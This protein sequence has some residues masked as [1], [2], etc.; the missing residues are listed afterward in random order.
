MTENKLKGYIYNEVTDGVTK[1]Y[2]E[3]RLKFT[4]DMI[5]SA[6][7]NTFLCGIQSNCKQQMYIQHFHS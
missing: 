6:S 4:Y 3:Y 7:C 1:Q 5:F 2:A